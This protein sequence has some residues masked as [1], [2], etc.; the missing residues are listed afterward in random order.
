MS[1]SSLKQ[2]RY[3]NDNRKS[4]TFHT[5]EIAKMDNDLFNSEIKT[6]VEEILA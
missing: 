3:E 4:V 5:K 2:Q 1:R 6:N